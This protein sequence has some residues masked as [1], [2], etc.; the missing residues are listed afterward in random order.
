MKIKIA[1]L[2]VLF[3]FLFLSFS[4]TKYSDIDV[5][6]LKPVR[7][8]SEF[9]DSSFMSGSVM[10][11][12]VKQDSILLT[13]YYMGQ[14]IF[15]DSNLNLINRVGESGIAPNEFV[16]AES[17]CVNDNNIYII[18]DGGNHIKVF[19]E[20]KFIDNIDFPKDIS[21][22]TWTRFFYYNN[23]IFHSVISRNVPAISFDINGVAKDKVCDFTKHDTYSLPLHSARHLIKGNNSFFVIGQ[24]LPIFEEYD[25]QCKRINSFDLTSVESISEVVQ[26]YKNSQQYP[27]KYFVMIQDVYFSN[28]KVFLLI[29]SNK[30]NYV[31]NRIIVL[32]VEN[33]IKQIAEFE[34]EGKVYL[35]FCVNNKRLFAFNALKAQ[36][37]EYELPTLN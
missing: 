7:A 27:D 37:E 8:L 16:R 36:L 6:W 1:Y 3:I 18:N 22:T 35:S 26:V 28:N 29:G 31:C 17:F 24:V 14:M 9:Q 5:I 20:N 32:S 34:L 4:C 15:L 25:M 21:L 13:D 33:V 19:N 23:S 11:M 10:C 12:D 30:D 2:I